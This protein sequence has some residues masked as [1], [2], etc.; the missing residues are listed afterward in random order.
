L[1]PP[2]GMPNPPA[3]VDINL[4]LELRRLKSPLGLQ[5]PPARVNINLSL[6]WR[7]L[8]EAQADLVRVA[9]ISNRAPHSCRLTID[10]MSLIEVIEIT[11]RSAK[12]ACAG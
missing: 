10:R 9:T 12:P 2:L 4:S 8:P 5:N 11:P 3:R 7:S 1:K 6:R